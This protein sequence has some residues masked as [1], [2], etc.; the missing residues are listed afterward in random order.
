MTPTV[1]QQA[2]SA[3]L[4]TIENFFER[5]CRLRTLHLNSDRCGGC[6]SVLDLSP[7]RCH[8]EMNSSRLN[9]LMGKQLGAAFAAPRSI[10]TKIF[11]DN[12]RKSA[13]SN[14]CNTR[15]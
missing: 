10:L 13:S 2:K 7:K 15:T 5:F 9:N 12:A 3:D 6:L 1:E 8:N 14:T 4:K 11:S